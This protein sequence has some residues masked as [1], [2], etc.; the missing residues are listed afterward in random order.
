MVLL[1]TSLSSQLAGSKT[2]WEN[3][4]YDDSFVQYTTRR[5]SYVLKQMKEILARSKIDQTGGEK[6]P[7]FASA[8]ISPSPPP[9]PQIN[10]ERKCC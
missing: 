9:L 4:N 10:R 7:H 1:L 2:F 5:N 3:T 8:V 6:D